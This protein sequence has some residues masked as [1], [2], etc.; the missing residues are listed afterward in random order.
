MD[1]GC[2]LLASGFGRRFGSNKL[3][4]PAGGVP[5]VRRA[6]ETYAGLP[7]ARRAVVSQYEAVLAMGPGFG[8]SPILNEE[9]AQGIS[10]SVRLG[11]AAMEGMEGVLFAVSDQPWLTPESVARLLS[12]FRAHPGRICA[13]AAEGRRGNP[14]VF[15]ADCFPDLL[16]L[17]GDAGGGQIIR[18][19]PERL[20]L[21]DACH[22]RELS[23]VDRPEDLQA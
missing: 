4:A 3:L 18:R 13:L 5:L 23:D 2:V 12:A 20:L 17:T 1:I 19:H 7:F 10:A 16:A 8:F 15:P 11:T 6:M 9:A 22:P 14:A 21:V